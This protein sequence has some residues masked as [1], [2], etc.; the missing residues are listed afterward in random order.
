MKVKQLQQTLVFDASPIQ[1]Y[2][3][4]TDQKLYSEFQNNDVEFDN[5]INGTFSVFDGYCTGMNLELIE[6]EKIV[7]KWNFAEENWPS[8][9][10]TLCTFLFQAF[11]NQTKLTFTQE[12]IP[13]HKYED[14][15]QGWYQ[16]YWEP[17]Q[18]FLNYK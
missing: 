6:G 4:L 13:E 14:L 16:Y 8:D 7:Q 3:L 1:V 2:N 15:A 5:S 9:H 12:D 17:M 18:A 11:G 10:Y